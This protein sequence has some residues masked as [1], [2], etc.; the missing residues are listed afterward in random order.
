MTLLKELMEAKKV[1]A[2]NLDA[3]AQAV[4]N[5]GSVDEKKAALNSMI[6]SFKFKAKQDKFRRQVAAASNPNKLDKLAGD[7]TL[8]DKDKVIK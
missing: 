7:I 2:K 4:W 6:D 5:A 1:E 8:A 3:M